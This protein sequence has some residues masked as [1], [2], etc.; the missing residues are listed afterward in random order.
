MGCRCRVCSCSWRPPRGG[1][2][3]PPRWLSVQRPGMRLCSLW[4]TPGRAALAASTGLPMGQAYLCS[5]CWRWSRGGAAGEPHDIGT[6]GMAVERDRGCLNWLRILTTLLWDPI[7]SWFGDR[8]AHGTPRHVQQQLLLVISTCSSGPAKVDAH[9][10]PQ[11]LLLLPDQGALA[12]CSMLWRMAVSVTNQLPEPQPQTAIRQSCH[13]CGSMAVLLG[14]PP[15]L[16]LLQL[17]AW[18]FFSGCTQSA[19]HGMRRH[20]AWPLPRATCHCWFL[21]GRKG[22]RGMCVF[23][24]LPLEGVMCT[25]WSGSESRTTGGTD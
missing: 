21:P 23:A 4:R 2:V 11:L 15:A 20:A 12:Y 25:F 22:A 5:S 18:R 1:A 6:G 9:G 7:Y 10:T 13:G 3:A 8:G 24:T 17:A 19:L 14:L 16:Q